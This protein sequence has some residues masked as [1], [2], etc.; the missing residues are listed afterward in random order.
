MLV[1]VWA[2]EW[3]YTMAAWMAVKMV[4]P[5]DVERIVSMAAVMVGIVVDLLV[6]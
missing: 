4:E 1:V 3:D 2:V 6:V 5:W